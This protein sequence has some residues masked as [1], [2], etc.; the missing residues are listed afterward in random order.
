MATEC[1]RDLDDL[2]YPEK[3]E[4][5]GDELDKLHPGVGDMFRK[6]LHEA[7]HHGFKDGT[8]FMFEAEGGEVNG[9]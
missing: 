7:Y 8:E 9:N 2:D 1:N 3:I 6:L 5:L 4:L